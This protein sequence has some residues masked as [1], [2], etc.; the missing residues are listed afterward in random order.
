MRSELQSWCM[1]GVSSDLLEEAFGK[2]M[3]TV[4]PPSSGYA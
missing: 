2:K 1:F 4:S 3:T